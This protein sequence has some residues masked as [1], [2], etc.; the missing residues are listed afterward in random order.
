MIEFLA[1]DPF[2]WRLALLA[3]GLAVGALMGAI[4]FGLLGWNTR[5]FVNGSALGAAGLQIAR[6]A[7]VGVVFFGLSKVGAG[8][9]IAGLAGLL[10][11]RHG[12]LRHS[13]RAR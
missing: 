13:G 12:M 11:A 10:A 7:L 6:L 2:L 9:L 8:A 3:F 5:L 4:H 1:N